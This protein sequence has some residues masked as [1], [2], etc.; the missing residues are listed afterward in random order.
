M[1]SS[2]C[3]PEPRA[4]TPPESVPGTRGGDSIPGRFATATRGRA[5]YGVPCRRQRHQSPRRSRAWARRCQSGSTR[6]AVSRYTRA[7]RSTLELSRAFVPASRITRPA[8]ADHDPLLG[9]PLDPDDGPVAQDLLRRLGLRGRPDPGRRRVLVV[10]LER[11][12]G[13]HDRVR[14]LVTGDRRAA[15]RAAARRR[16]SSRADRRRRRP[17]S[18]AGPRG[19]RADDLVDERVDALA[20]ARRERDERVEVAELGR[21]RARAG[22][23]TSSRLASVDLVDHEDLRRRAP[24]APAP[25]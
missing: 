19:S 18:S 14:Q 10:V 17:G 11:L 2:L 1:P 6:T 20:G 22:R 21:R 24:G 25:R 3:G 9:V 5:T 15:S 4:R 8:L 12:G 7:P 16:A 23:P 13:H